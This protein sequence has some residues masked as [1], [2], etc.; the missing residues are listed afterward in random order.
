ML[1]R[2]RGG[3]L[4]GASVRSSTARRPGVDIGALPVVDPGNDARQTETGNG[5]L[6][7]GMM[8]GKHVDGSAPRV[9]GI[10]GAVG[11]SVQVEGMVRMRIHHQLE[12][13]LPRLG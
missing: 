8:A 10:V 1:A 12:G 13:N 4:A 3:I 6:P 5:Q 2:D 11:P 9:C 7:D